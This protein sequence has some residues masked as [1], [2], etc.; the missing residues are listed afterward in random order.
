MRE[1]TQKLKQ[2]AD[3][4]TAPKKKT[5]SKQETGFVIPPDEI[6]NLATAFEELTLP[7]AT[8]KKNLAEQHE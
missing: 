4:V 7:S 6:E 3:T 5:K 8:R 2:N 1:L